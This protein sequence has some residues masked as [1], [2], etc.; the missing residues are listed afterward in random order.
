[1]LLGLQAAYSVAVKEVDVSVLVNTGGTTLDV[2][3]TV[4]MLAGA[5][6]VDVTVIVLRG[7]PLIVIVD[8]F[9]EV[10]CR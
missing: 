9:V 2:V 8:I 7:L 5:V 10:A 6:L 3:T 4:L 1:M